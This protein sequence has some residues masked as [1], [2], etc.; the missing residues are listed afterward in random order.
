MAPLVAG[1]DFALVE[2]TDDALEYIGENLRQE[3]RDEVFATLGH[4]RYVDAL[5]VSVLASDATAVGVSAYGEPVAVFGVTP[6]SVLYNTGSPWFM[7]TPR[8]R[9]YR[10]ALIAGGRAYTALML[11]Q[12]ARLENHVD[13]RNTTSVAWLQ[14]LGFTVEAPAPHGVLRLPF[15]RFS[16]ER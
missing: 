14:R 15:H 12:Y 9:K 5:R 8:V 16:I 3:D 11:K 4:A 6:V 2:C 7:G 1:P 10:R 13:A